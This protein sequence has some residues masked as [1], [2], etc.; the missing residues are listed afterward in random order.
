MFIV[1]HRTEAVEAQKVFEHLAETLPKE[2]ESDIEINKNWRTIGVNGSRID[3]RCGDVFKLGGLRPNYYNTDNEL[4]SCFLEQSAVK[5]NGKEIKDISEI[6]TL[7]KGGP[8]GNSR[9]NKI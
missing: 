4:A 6:V 9:T 8:Y 7:V 3:F 2:L 1:I 5:V